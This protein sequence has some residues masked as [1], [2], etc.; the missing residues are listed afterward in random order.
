MGIINVGQGK[1]GFVGG[2]WVG[3]ANVGDVMLCRGRFVRNVAV[4]AREATSGAQDT[5]GVVVVRHGVVVV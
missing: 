1:F 5:R 2:R 3:V 4:G